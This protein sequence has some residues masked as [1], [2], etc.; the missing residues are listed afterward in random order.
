MADK[1]RSVQ[2]P[3]MAGD[4]MLSAGIVVFATLV[5][6][7]GMGFRAG[8]SWS[9]PPPANDPTWYASKA[10]FYLFNFVTELV[11]VFLYAV[12]RVDRLFFTPGKGEGVGPVESRMDSTALEIKGKGQE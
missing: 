4:V 11:V 5:L 1:V 7:I 6:V 9:T 10:C 2:R 12:V 3:T 8:T